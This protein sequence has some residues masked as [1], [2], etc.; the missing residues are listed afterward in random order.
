MLGVATAQFASHL[1]VSVLPEAAKVARQL[2]R[3]ITRRKQFHQDGHTAIVNTRRFLH[4]KTFLQADAQ[5]RSICTLTVIQTDATARGHNN[6]RWS[7]TLY[8]LLQVV[9][10]ECPK[11]A[12]QVDF[13][14]C[15]S[16]R[17]QM[18]GIV[19]IKR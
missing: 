15:C 1:E 6:M 17:A 3:L 18:P 5:H 2:H 4:P 7:Q 11:R 10:N 14:K 12:A 16:C 8:L 9:G 13:A 19:K